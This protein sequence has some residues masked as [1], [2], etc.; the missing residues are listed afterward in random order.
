MKKIF[1]SV[2]LILICF[3]I[4]AQDK[5]GI[6]SIPFVDGNVI[7]SS[8]EQ[9]DSVSAQNIYS[10]AK[11][12]IV[13]IFVSAKDVIQIDDKENHLLVAKGITKDGGAS[14]SYTIKIQAKDG[15]YKIDLYDCQYLAV[16]SNSIPDT[17]YG[18]EKLTDENCLNKKGECK[19]TGYGYARRFLID[20]KDNIFS[21]V[22]AKIK[23]ATSKTN[24]DW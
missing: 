22:N 11:M 16:I 4:N 5:Y 14:W 1:Y 21:Q 19:K 18:A 23:Q 3:V 13:D 24:D 2:S 15:R 20:T 17:K 10:Y 7:F 8:I 9:I 6:N 12:A